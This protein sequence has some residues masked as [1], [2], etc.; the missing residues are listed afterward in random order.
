MGNEGQGVDYEKLRL[1]QQFKEYEELTSQLQN[2]NLTDL[3]ENEKKA[4]FISILSIFYVETVFVMH[5]IMFEHAQKGQSRLFEKRWYINCQK[6]L[7]ID[8][9]LVHIQWQILHAIFNMIFIFLW[10]E[11]TKALHFKCAFTMCKLTVL[12]LN[13][14]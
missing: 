14:L 5:H 8:W 7:Q 12:R 3:S 4:F 11:N 6:M 10:H 2:V 1:S 9:L 13:L